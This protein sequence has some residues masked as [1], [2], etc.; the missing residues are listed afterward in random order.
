MICGSGFELK[1][2][3]TRTRA[4][5]LFETLG[6]GQT[7]TVVLLTLPSINSIIYTKGRTR[8][9][10]TGAD[11]SNFCKVNRITVAA[12]GLEQTRTVIFL[13]LPSINSIIY[14]KGRTRRQWTGADTK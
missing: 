1:I 9:Q 4:T 10:W 5:D 2:A 12:N 7:Q 13:T 8:R 6:L 3:P 14:T 11:T